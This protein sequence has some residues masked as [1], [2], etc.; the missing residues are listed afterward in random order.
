MIETETAGHLWCH[1][2]VH[3]STLTDRV[4]TGYDQRGRITQVV[5]DT[6]PGPR[7]QRLGLVIPGFG[8]AHSHLFHRGLRGRTH[9]G[10]GDFWRWRQAMYE[11]AGALNPDSY[12]LLA[13]AT[14]AEMVACGSTAVGE[15]HYLHHR[16]DATPYP[17]HAMERAVID[18][19]AETGI[20]LTLLDTCY[21]T[22]GIDAELSPQQQRFGD[23][24][25]PARR[26]ADAGA[27]IAIGSGQQAVIDRCWSCVAWK[28]ANGS[29]AAAAASSTPASCGRPEP[30][31]AMPAWASA[32]MIWILVPGVIW[33]NSTLSRSVRR[34]RSPPNWRR[35]QP[36][37][38][39][40]KR[41]SAAGWSTTV[42][43][44]S[45]TGD[46]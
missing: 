20:R 26:L 9:A 46:T 24:I 30:A 33:S 2:V 25:G 5:S 19:A 22:G 39:C 14:Y 44:I 21:L 13:R 43:P 8:N 7:D 40:P 45:N 11:L 28:P 23:G 42:R 37:P 16:P 15:F 1:R 36:R 31:P 4:R 3:G 38:M 12:R 32:A 17:G 34:V 10:G 18:A 35:W 41:S 6:D 29:R 27:Q